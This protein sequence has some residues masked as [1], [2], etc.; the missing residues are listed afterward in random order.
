MTNVDLMVLAG[1]YVK[2][3]VISEWKVKVGDRVSKGDVLLEVETN[4]VVQGI[5]SPCDG[6]VEQILFEEGDD[7]DISKTVAV[8]GDGAA[9][10]AAAPSE[11]V[12]ASP[13]ASES[14]G[15]AKRER[16]VI[17]PVAKKMAKEMGIDLDELAA[18][19]PG[20]RISKDDVLEFASKGKSDAEPTAQD[21]PESAAVQTVPAADAPAVTGY[22]SRECGE[23]SLQL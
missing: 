17:S 13:S 8:I 6:I 20:K 4:K 22:L 14:S 12:S 7:V 9:A 21:S 1:D 18:E 5:E 16:T 2:T 3:A 19:Y 15:G 10:S 11:P 23:L